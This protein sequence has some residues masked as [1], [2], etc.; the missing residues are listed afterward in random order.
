MLTMLANLF[1]SNWTDADLVRHLWPLRLVQPEWVGLLQHYDYARWS[2]AETYA[3]LAVVFMVWLS[4]TG[5]LSK[6]YWAGRGVERGTRHRP[7]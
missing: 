5:L 7:T 4:A 1:P 6:H 2:I 3:R